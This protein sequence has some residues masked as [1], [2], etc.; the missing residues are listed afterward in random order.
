MKILYFAS[1]R[2]KVGY[3]DEDV[4]V[5]SAITSIGDLVA[6]LR[7]RG[8]NYERALADARTVRV[9]VNQDHVKFDHPVHADDEVAFF[10]PV[11][12]GSR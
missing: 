6:W 8:D 3:A 4:S 10:P 11:T 7:S 5:P 2:E 12:G 9:A 1:I